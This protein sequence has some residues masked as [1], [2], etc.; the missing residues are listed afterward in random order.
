MHQKYYVRHPAS[1]SSTLSGLGLLPSECFCPSLG[2]FCHHPWLKYY[3]S[4][5]L[6]PFL[7]HVGVKRLDPKGLRLGSWGRTGTVRVW[8]WQTSAKTRQYLALKSHLWLLCNVDIYTFNAIETHIKLYS[9][10]KYSKYKKT[11]VLSTKKI[12]EQYT[13]LTYA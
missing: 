4:R 13:H 9:T 5:G 7:Y 8:A 12:K 2:K 10:Y 11:Y 6:K 3:S 1:N